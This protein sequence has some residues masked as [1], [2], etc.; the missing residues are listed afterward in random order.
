MPL[1]TCPN[2]GLSEPAALA[3][4][5][6]GPCPRCCARLH[7]SDEITWQHPPPLPFPTDGPRLRLALAPSVEAPALARRAVAGLQAELNDD[8]LFTAQ[9]LV[10]EL[11]SNVVRHAANGSPPRAIARLWISA[12]RLRVDVVDRGDGFRPRAAFPPPGAE[13]GWGLPLVAELSDDWGVVAGHGSW[14]WFELRRERA[15]APAEASTRRSERNGRSGASVD[16]SKRRRAQSPSAAKAALTSSRYARS[17]TAS[18]RER[19]SWKRAR[20]APLPT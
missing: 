9:L 11:V 1:Y 12:D 6:P 18:P 16:S 5:E 14:V 7:P 13:S 10:S 20:A 19:A 8:E 3:A 15:Q 17:T 2:C 4:P